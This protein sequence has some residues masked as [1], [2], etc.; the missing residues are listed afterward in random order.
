MRQRPE[1]SSSRYA[2]DGPSG[3][4]NASSESVSEPRLRTAES[5]TRRTRQ[6]YGAPR[7]STRNSTRLPAV[8][9]RS[10][11][12]AA[13]PRTVSP[14]RPGMSAPTSSTAGVMPTLPAVS[15]TSDWTT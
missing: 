10:G 14:G 4:R 3:A 7:A 15:R 1:R 8:T 9:G 13:I 11:G 2:P 6:R 5:P 12:C